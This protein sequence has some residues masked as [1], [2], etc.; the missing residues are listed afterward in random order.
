MGNHVAVSVGGSNGHFEL[1]VFK[2]VMI[3]NLLEVCTRGAK[4]SCALSNINTTLVLAP[5]TANLTSCC[6]A[7]AVCSPHWRRLSVVHRQLRGGHPG[8]QG[9]H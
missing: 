3:A 2:P 4:P 9:E 6:A 5:V 7:H 1:N 8:Q